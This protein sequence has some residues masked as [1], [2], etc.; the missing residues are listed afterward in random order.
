MGRHWHPTD[1]VQQLGRE[2]S[3]KV[4]EVERTIA[5]LRELNK[6]LKEQRTKAQEA[7]AKIPVKRSHSLLC[8]VP[9]TDGVGCDCGKD[10]IDEARRVL[11]I[12]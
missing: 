1:T 7:V 5:D 2:I 4:A 3:A 6:A 12:G 9:F 8:G 10:A 11:D